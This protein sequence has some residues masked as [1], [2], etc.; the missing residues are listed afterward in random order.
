MRGVSNPASSSGSSLVEDSDDEGRGSCIASLLGGFSVSGVAPPS[1]ASAALSF[2]GVS[3][4]ES[5]SE[6]AARLA[7]SVVSE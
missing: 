4:A 7:F 1:E 5:P 3:V 2:A 6:F